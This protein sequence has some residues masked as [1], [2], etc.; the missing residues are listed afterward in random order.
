MNVVKVRIIG[1]IYYQMEEQIK[2]FIEEREALN[3]R[4]L[5]RL[6]GWQYPNM[7]SWKSGK[8]PIPK[9]RLKALSEV[10]KDYGFDQKKESPDGSRAEV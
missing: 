7:H 3:I 9:Q 8:R 1:Y 5:S 6:I 4:A 10:L 2:Q